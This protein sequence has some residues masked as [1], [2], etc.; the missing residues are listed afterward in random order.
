[1]GHWY[2][3]ERSFYLLEVTAGCT[4]I[5]L[6]ENLDGKIEVVARVINKW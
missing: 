3:I 6:Q 1:M 4:T 2:E 5:E